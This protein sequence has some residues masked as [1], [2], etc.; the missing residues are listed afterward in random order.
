MPIDFN[1]KSLYTIGNNTGNIT[2][3]I[4]YHA[5]KPF[6]YL[7]LFQGGAYNYNKPFMT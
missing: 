2:G 1:I 3:N 4:I 5:N 7:N 6:I